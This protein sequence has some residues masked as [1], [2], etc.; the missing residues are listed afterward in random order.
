MRLRGGFK[1]ER[2]FSVLWFGDRVWR[3]PLTGVELI[4]PL[5]PVP[6]QGLVSQACAITPGQEPTLTETETVF[7]S[8]SARK[9]FGGKGTSFN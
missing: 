1:G 7:L 3:A 4:T 5:L 9:V 8:F 2:N 6:S